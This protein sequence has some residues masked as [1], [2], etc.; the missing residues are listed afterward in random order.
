MRATAYKTAT[1]SVVR[2]TAV[3]VLLL[4]AFSQPIAE[5]LGY[6]DH[7]NYIIWFAFILGFDT[8]VA[9]P[10]A[11][12]RLEGKALKFAVVRLTNLLVHLGFVTLFLY[13]LPN[14]FPQYYD[15]TMGIGYVFLANLLA[16]AVTFA[17]LLPTYWYK[18]KDES[19]LDSVDAPQYDPQLLKQML[20]YSMP[21]VL[22]GFAGII[23]EVLDRIL[24]IVLLEC[25]TNVVLEQI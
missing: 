6:P 23:N 18:I 13:L 7:A 12:L 20:L 9:I 17:L 24:L 2:T 14:Y 21:L 25:D 16:S 19:S 11:L 10:Y 8:L 4:I 5:L 1:T 3:L 15:P 22:A